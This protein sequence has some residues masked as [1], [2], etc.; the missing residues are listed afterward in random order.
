MRYD[1]T[2]IA[3]IAHV[4]FKAARTRRGE[5]CSV[6]KANVLETMGLWRE[7]VIEVGR[8]YPDVALSHLYADAAA[9]ALAR[10]PKQ[11]DVIVAPNLFGDILS[12][13]AA[14]IGGSIGM[15]PSASVGEGRKGL[16]EPIHGSAPD[17]AGQDIANPLG[18]ILSVAMML[19]LTFRLD[20]AAARIE[21]AVRS[22]LAAGLRTRDIAEPGMRVVGTKAMGEAVA[23]AL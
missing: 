2:E 18:T 19:R 3:R 1:E 21:A 5:L 8:D 16:Y 12:D 13:E 6:D 10:A 15:L 4:A 14:V 20:D 9:M 22:V 7:V 11:F 23:A 17:I